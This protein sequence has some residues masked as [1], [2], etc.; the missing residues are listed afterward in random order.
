MDDWLTLRSEIAEPTP[1]SE[2]ENGEPEV[3]AES[4]T[5]EAQFEVKEE[6]TNEANADVAATEQEAADWF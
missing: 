1:V 6:P 4:P 2:V 3:V 5:A